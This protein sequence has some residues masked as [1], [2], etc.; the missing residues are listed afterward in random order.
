MEYLRE[1]RGCT[2][3]GL[4]IDPDRIA[5]A[6]ARG[7]SVIQGDLDQGL[8]VY[9]DDSFDVAVLAQTLQ[10]VRSPALV[11]RE[12]LRVA[13]RAVVS[14]PNFGHWRVRAHLALRGR[15]PVSRAIPF[16]WYE[17]P[18]IHHTTITDFRD[19]VRAHGGVLETEL[20]LLSR[21]G[22]TLRAA[23]VAPNLRA[24]LAVAVVRRA[25]TATV[26]L[27]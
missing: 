10:V 3:R 14:F 16:T 8:T 11:L 5:T 6:I 1:E 22:D 19:F 20:P 2:V 13:D 27:D 25:R 15:M 26:A 7:L 17:T 18:N 12:M 4:K 9:P 23:H 21:R 24:D